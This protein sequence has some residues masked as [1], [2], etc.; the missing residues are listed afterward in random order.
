MVSKQ[1]QTRHKN[2]LTNLYKMERKNEFLAW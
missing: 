2:K 1:V